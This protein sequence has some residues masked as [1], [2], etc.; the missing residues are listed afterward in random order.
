YGGTGNA[1]KSTV[2][3]RIDDL[4]VAVTTSGSAGPIPTVTLTGSPTPFTTPAGTAPASQSITV[5]G[6]QL[7]DNAIKIKA[8]PGFEVSA[9]NS[10]FTDSLSINGTSGTILSTSLFVRISSTAGAGAVG[11]N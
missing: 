3:W 2:N 10:L 1:A 7:T 4:S 9:D 5:S 6:S 11:G 8:P